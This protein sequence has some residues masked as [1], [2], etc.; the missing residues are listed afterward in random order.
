ML[1]MVKAM[2]NMRAAAV[3]DMGGCGKLWSIAL[4]VAQSS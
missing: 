1:R 4:Q 3:I 2:F